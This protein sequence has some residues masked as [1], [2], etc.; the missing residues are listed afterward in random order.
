MM[1]SYNRKNDQCRTERVNE[2]FGYVVD[3]TRDLEEGR[4]SNTPSFSNYTD[5]V[6]GSRAEP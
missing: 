4:R 1:L 5:W 6:I 2:V 3:Q